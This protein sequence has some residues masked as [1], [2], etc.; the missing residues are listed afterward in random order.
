MFSNTKITSCSQVLI[1]NG[2][3]VCVGFRSAPNK[4]I[5]SKTKRSAENMD[6]FKVRQ[7]L[8]VGMIKKPLEPYHPNAHRSRLPSPTVVMPYK[9]S[10]QIVIGDR[11]SFNKKQFVSTQQANH[12]AVQNF[13]TSNPGIVAEKTKRQK[14]LI[15][16]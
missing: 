3:A 10:S 4:P 2:Q 9:N 8:H 14:H 12:Q 5:D 16:L 11:S 15:N 7:N 13:G 1:K 6:Q